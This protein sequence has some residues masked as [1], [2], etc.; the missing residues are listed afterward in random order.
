MYKVTDL[1]GKPRA[2]TVFRA[3]INEAERTRRMKLWS[4]AVTRT[5]DWVVD[6]KKPAK[7]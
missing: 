2:S 3:A 6:E 1:A 7:L 5:F 4:K